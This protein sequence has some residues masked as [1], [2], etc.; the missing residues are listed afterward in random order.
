MRWETTSL[1]LSDVRPLK[2]SIPLDDHLTIRLDENTTLNI[3]E[4][5]DELA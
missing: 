4:Q 5:E 2:V 1:D 3:V